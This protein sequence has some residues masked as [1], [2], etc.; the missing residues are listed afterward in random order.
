LNA[1]VPAAPVAA[2]RAASSRRGTSD[3]SRFAIGWLVAVIGAAPVEFAHAA[4]SASAEMGRNALKLATTIVSRTGPR[5]MRR[6][7]GRY[8]VV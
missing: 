1:S 4:S 6:P 2:S 3:G 7:N 5:M 8:T